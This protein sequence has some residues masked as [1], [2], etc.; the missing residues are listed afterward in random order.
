MRVFLCQFEQE[1][2]SFTADTYARQWKVAGNIHLTSLGHI[3]FSQTAKHR[4]KQIGCER[5]SPKEE[6]KNG[7]AG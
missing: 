7:A 3:F 2:W 4:K 5:S 6:K 1:L